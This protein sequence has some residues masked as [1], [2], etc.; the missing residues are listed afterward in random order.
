MLGH[1]PLA[2]E[3]TRARE[4]TS[5]DRV[6]EEDGWRPFRPDNDSDMSV[7][8]TR[9][10]SGGVSVRPCESM[11]NCCHAAPSARSHAPQ[12][13]EQVVAVRTTVPPEPIRADQGADDAW[14]ALSASQTGDRKSF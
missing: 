1:I 10:E 3:A 8:L 14:V 6:G 11:R 12:V 9:E 13:Q 5:R 2:Q 4:P 7:P